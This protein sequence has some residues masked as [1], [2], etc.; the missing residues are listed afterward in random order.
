MTASLWWELLG[1]ARLEGI[2]TL[3]ALAALASPRR[4]APRRPKIRTLDA[5]EGIG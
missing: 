4:G 3:E 1:R 2:H 5:S